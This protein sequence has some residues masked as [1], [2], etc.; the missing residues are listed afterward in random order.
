MKTLRLTRTELNKIY[1]LLEKFPEVTSFE[2]IEE[3]HAGI[4]SI[5]TMEFT[6]TVNSVEG[7]FTVEIY[8]IETW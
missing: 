5:L 1:V 4:G 2:L 3:Q 8:G 6:N 7:K